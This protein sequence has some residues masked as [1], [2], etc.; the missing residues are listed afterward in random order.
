[1]SFRKIVSLTSLTAF[2]FILTTGVVL[3][4]VP[5]GRVAYWADWRLWGLTKEDWSSIHINLALLFLIASG[6]HIYYNWKAIVAYLKNRSKQ[7]VVFNR[8][9][10]IALVV[11]VVFAA[12]TYLGAPPFKTLLDASEAIKMSAER[13]YG[14]PPYG[15]AEQSSLKTFCKK[16]GLDLEKSV[17]LLTEHNLREVGKEETLKDIARANGISP[18]Q[19]YLLI[20]GVGKAASGGGKDASAGSPPTA[21]S[22]LG[23][24]T[25]AQGTKE[26][27]LDLK[28]GL[29]K[30]A[31]KNIQAAPD[32]TFREVA[33]AAGMSPMDLYDIMK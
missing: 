3:Y 33:E 20:K 9:F 28:A 11:S 24:K 13:E 30:L 4:I 14:N 19:V 26:Y 31:Q 23:R 12:G 27:G 8:E 29:A 1:M 5:H 25:L 15:H 18:Q 2:V 32:M 6:F 10:T 7:L 21:P 22:G 17:I 16:M